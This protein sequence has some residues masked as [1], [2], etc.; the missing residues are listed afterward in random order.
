MKRHE[1]NP[2]EGNR[3]QAKLS[4][5]DALLKWSAF[6]LTCV[7]WPVVVYHLWRLWA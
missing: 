5:S 7:G 1:M 4:R 2:P 6:A 3:V